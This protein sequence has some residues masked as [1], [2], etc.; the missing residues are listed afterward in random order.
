[1]S[2][3]ITTFAL[4]AVLAFTA[5][6]CQKD[7]SN[8]TISSAETNATVHTVRYTIDGMQ[9]TISLVGNKAWH[10]F[11]NRMFALAEEGREVSFCNE[12]AFSSV[13]ISKEIITH[14]TY[15][16]DEAYKW[17]EEMYDKGYGVT[18]SYDEKTKTYTCYAIK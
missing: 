6:S 14:T 18:I 1:M 7:E 10:D 16:K 9:R 8:S 17:A 13:A 11:I 15:N 5:V 12:E 3:K 2:K 4:I